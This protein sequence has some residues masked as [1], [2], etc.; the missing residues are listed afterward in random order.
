MVTFERWKFEDPADTNPLTRS[1]VFEVNPNVMGSPFPTRNVTTLGT[2]AVDGKVLLW[3]GMRSPAQMTISGV[4]LSRAQ[5]YELE[6]WVLGKDGRLFLYD[7]FGRRMVVIPLAFKP[8]PR[9]AV[10]S[11]PWIHDYSIDLIVV[12]IAQPTV[13]ED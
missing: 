10:G 2:T 11:H 8:E 6:R 9:R 3:E 13:L 1:Y 5:Y 4:S 7:H 12:S